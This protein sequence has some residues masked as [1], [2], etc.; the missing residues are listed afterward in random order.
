MS[1]IGLLTPEWPAPA[2]V[3]AV[4][5]LRTG[6][7]SGGPY[8]SFNLATHVGDDAGAVAE[9]RKR[10]RAAL[11]FP[12]EPAWLNQ[13]H[14]TVVVDAASVANSLDAASVTT[15]P[16]ADASVAIESR[17]VC[18]IQTA[19]CLPV[20]FCDRNGTR[21]GAAHAGWRGLVGGVLTNTVHALNVSPTNVIAWLGPAIEVEAFEVGEDVRSAFLSREP[22]D[23]V[24]FTPNARGR[25]QA[26]LYALARRELARAGVTQVSGGGERCY[27]DHERFFSYRR[28]GQTGRMATLI[29]LT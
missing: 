18:V 6:G 15:P 20:L 17:A 2:N 8:A 5:T 11:R 16:D 23:A 9:N 12:G 26:D 14:G 1:D 4:T 3:R 22:S 24:A 21:V 25:W 10:L 27:A 13:V 19:D 7:V 29:F 28:D